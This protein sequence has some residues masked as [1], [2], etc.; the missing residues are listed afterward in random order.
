MVREIKLKLFFRKKRN[1]STIRI[2]EISTEGRIL[3]TKIE[4]LFHQTISFSLGIIDTTETTARI[5][6]DTMTTP[7]GQ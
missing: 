7:N 1:V 5:S 4:N 3:S 2:M 6:T